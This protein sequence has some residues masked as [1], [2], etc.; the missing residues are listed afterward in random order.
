MQEV[1]GDVRQ[2]FVQDAAYGPIASHVQAAAEGEAQ[3]AVFRRIVDIRNAAGSEVAE[4][5]GVIRTPGAAVAL[6]P[7]SG[8]HGVEQPPLDGPGAASK[9]ARVFLQQD[10]QQGVPQDG[11][12]EVVGVGCPEALCVAFDALAVSLIP[13]VDLLACT[14]GDGLI[15][16]SESIGCLAVQGVDTGDGERDRVLHRVERHIEFLARGERRD[17]G[18]I[19]NIE[20]GK[21]A[22]EALLL[23]FLDL[24]GR[25]VYVT[26]VWRCWRWRWCCR[27]GCGLGRRSRLRVERDHWRRRIGQY[28]RRDY[29]LLIARLRQ[30]YMGS[31]GEKECGC[32]CVLRAPGMA[33]GRVPGSGCD[34]DS[35]DD[36]AL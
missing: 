11:A 33:A 15:F 12:T 6:A 36:P 8:G 34:D 26:L 13:H 32:Q 28:G 3:A 2:E 9:E 4:D 22:E 30:R 23:L 27:S 29:D 31:G 35:N 21:N 18:V 1:A 7:D 24:R 25:P 20:V 19:G 14:V 17:V 10:W 5:V 16:R